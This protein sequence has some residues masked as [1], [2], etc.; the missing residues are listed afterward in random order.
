MQNFSQAALQRQT[1]PHE[2]SRPKRPP[3]LQ[4]PQKL[5]EKAIIASVGIGRMPDRIE[6]HCLFNLAAALGAPEAVRLRQDVAAEMT[7]EEIADAQRL[8]RAYRSYTQ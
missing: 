3:V 7:A 8:A 1:R 2:N 5:I 4:D 6:A